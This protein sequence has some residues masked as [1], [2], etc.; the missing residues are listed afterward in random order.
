[1][2]GEL[3]EQLHPERM[4][5]ALEGPRVETTHGFVGR[6]RDGGHRVVGRL[7]R[8]GVRAVAHRR[9]LTHRST[10]RGHSQLIGGRG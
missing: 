6:S 8:G 3:I 7:G 2:I 10:S 5:E 9:L 1:M 4:R